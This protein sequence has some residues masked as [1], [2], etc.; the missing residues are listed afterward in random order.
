MMLN[1]FLYSE[2]G[3]ESSPTRPIDSAVTENIGSRQ[4]TKTPRPTRS[5]PDRRIPNSKPHSIEMFKELDLLK[6]FRHD[7]ISTNKPVFLLT[8]SFDIENRSQ[9]ISIISYYFEYLDNIFQSRPDTSY[10][11]LINYSIYHYDDWLA[12]GLR[13]T[14]FITQNPGLFKQK[15]QVF[16]KV[17]RHYARIHPKGILLVREKLVEMLTTKNLNSG[18]AHVPVISFEMITYPIVCE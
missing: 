10:L 15:N 2:E 13:F 18:N 4:T 14:E 11:D 17:M 9:V 16:A 3:E 7:L 6:L 1:R 8:N 12:Y 5:T